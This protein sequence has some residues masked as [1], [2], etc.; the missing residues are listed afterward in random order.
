MKLTRSMFSILIWTLCLLALLSSSA[1]AWSNKEHILLTQLAVAGLL[2]DPNTPPDMKAWLRQAAPNLPDTEA[3][4]QWFLHQ[5]IGL[6]PR[7]VN[8]LAYWSTMPDMMAMIE[9]PD[10]KIEPFGVGEAKLHFIDIEL[11]N[12][13]PARRK[14]LPDLS[15]RPALADF[16]RDINDDRYKQAGMLPFRVEDCFKHLV[17]SVRENHLLDAPGQYPRDEHATKWAGYLAHYVQDNTQ[18]HHATLD[19]KSFSYFPN[20]R[21]APN[22]HNQMEYIMVDDDKDDYM[23]LREEFW[24]ALINALRDF[25]DPV[26]TADPWQSTLEVALKSYGALPLIGQA[27]A[28]ATKPADSPTKPQLIDTPAFFHFKGIYLDRNTTVL[29]M[30]AHQQAWAIRRTQNLWRQAWDQAKGPGREP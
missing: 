5:H 19:Y 3:Q 1:F 8:G 2:A 22:I 30:K 28:A 14:Y 24:P 15:S 10:Q 12:P 6:I 7:G 21:T 25:H 9:R 27:A 17:K 16:P 13:D 29:E 20:P 23:S 26:Q 11:F 4:K 18:P